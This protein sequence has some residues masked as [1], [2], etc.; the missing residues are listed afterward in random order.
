MKSH[1]RLS[2]VIPVLLI[3]GM[4]YSIWAYY[5][6]GI[7]RLRTRSEVW[8]LV[9]AAAILMNF[10]VRRLRENANHEAKGRRPWLDPGRI[11][12]MMFGGGAV[13][14]A[15]VF[16]LG[17]NAAADLVTLVTVLIILLYGGFSI[18]SKKTDKPTI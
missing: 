8:L 15:F 13:V 14:S 2:F 12:W 17:K 1:Q 10:F 5:M 6:G 3:T 16:G 7:S 18:R 11:A 9:S 4:C